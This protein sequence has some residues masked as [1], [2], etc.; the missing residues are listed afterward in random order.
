MARCAYCNS[1]LLF[2]GAKVGPYTF[3]NAKCQQGAHY[4]AISQQIPESTIQQAIQHFDLSGCPKCKGPGPIEVHTSHLVW[5]AL[6]LT[7]WSSRPRVCCRSCGIKSQLG[8]A[9]LDMLIGW[10]GFP[11]G[12]IMTPVQVG[13]NIIG[14]FSVPPHPSN[15]L[16]RIIG[17]NMAAQMAALQQRAMPPLPPASPLPPL[18]TPQS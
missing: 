17:L 15:Q 9:A 4:L 10:W 6:V 13:R 11:W 7:S 18:P 2:G 1:L 14:I 16:K 3:C 8:Y 12:L 5:S